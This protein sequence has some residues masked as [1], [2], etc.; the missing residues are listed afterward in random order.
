MASG[1]KINMVSTSS[2][3]RIAALEQDHAAG[4]EKMRKLKHDD[5]TV[6]TASV[7]VQL[8]SNGYQKW[9]YLRFKTSGK[10]KNWYLGKV[11]AETHAE[12]LAIG[13]KLAREKGVIERLGWSWLVNDQDKPL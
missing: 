10:T 2:K 3:N 5:G 12:S 8:F 6:A 7:S 4:G 1:Q 13:W 9:G 11:S